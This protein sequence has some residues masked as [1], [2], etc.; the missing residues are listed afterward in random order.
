M[1]SILKTK[2]YKTVIKQLM[3]DTKSIFIFTDGTKEQDE[4]KCYVKKEDLLKEALKYRRNDLYV[5]SLE[6]ALAKCKNEYKNKTIF[7]VG[8]FYTYK[9]VIENLKK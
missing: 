2:D 3:E 4:V 1:L 7:I 9:E 8:S 6:G 5:N